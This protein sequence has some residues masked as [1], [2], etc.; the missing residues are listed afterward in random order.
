MDLRKYT[1]PEST[2]GLI[3]LLP[4]RR[5]VA[6]PSEDTLGV[7]KGSLPQNIHFKAGHDEEGEEEV[8]VAHAAR[9]AGGH[10]EPIS[11]PE[12]PKQRPAIMHPEKTPAQC[13]NAS[14]KFTLP[15]ANH[16]EDL[17]LPSDAS[18]SMQSEVSEPSRVV[19]LRN[20]TSRSPT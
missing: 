8:R 12:T 5:A 15:L 19:I 20:V 3:A 9:T 7:V 14:H 13:H 10:D 2:D 1:A 6:R 18:S 11:Q 16:S 17:A 4:R